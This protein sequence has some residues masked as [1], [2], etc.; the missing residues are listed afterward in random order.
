MKKF[1]ALF[2]VTYIGLTILVGMGFH[3]LAPD[4]HPSII[5]TIDILLSVTLVGFL[6]ARQHK[7]ILT[8]PEYG[9]IVISCIVIDA[10]F[11]F[12]VCL[13]LLLSDTPPPRPFLP[14]YLLVVGL[15]A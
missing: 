8:R 1:I 2:A 6:F 15:H 4:S 10:A 14:G 13:P 7:R 11:Q 12:L 5:N 3:F 9:T